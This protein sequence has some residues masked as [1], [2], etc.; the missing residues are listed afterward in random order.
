MISI[1]ITQVSCKLG[2][3]F[4]YAIISLSKTVDKYVDKVQGKECFFKG[5]P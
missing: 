1:S 5:N 3:A 2:Y 4:S